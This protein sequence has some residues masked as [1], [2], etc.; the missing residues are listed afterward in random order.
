SAKSGGFNWKHSLGGEKFEEWHATGNLPGRRPLTGRQNHAVPAWSFFHGHQGAGGRC[1]GGAGRN[2]RSVTHGHVSHQTASLGDASG[3]AD[4][5][6]RHD[7]ARYGLAVPEGA[8]STGRFV[9][10]RPH[11]TNCGG[12]SSR[13]DINHS[14]AA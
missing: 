5:N 12:T 9:L 13:S 1:A 8:E 3:Q 6:R 14:P 4:F 11:V 10:R 7:F 2:L